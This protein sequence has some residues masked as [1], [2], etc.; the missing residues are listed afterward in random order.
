M[1]RR[2]S[3]HSGFS[4]ERVHHVVTYVLGYRKVSA[5][6]VPKGLNVKQKATRM[7]IG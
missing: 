4:V 5:V 7:G 6:W 2:I 3:E 1:L